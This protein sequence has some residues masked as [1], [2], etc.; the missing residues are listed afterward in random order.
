MIEQPSTSGKKSLNKL[1]AIISIVIIVATAVVIV[2]EEKKPTTTTSK[3]VEFHTW[4]A[5]EGK[6]ALDHLGPN[7]TAATGYTMTPYISPGVGGTNAI[8]AILSLMEAGKPPA[9]FQIHYG[10]AMLSHVEAASNGTKPF[11]NR[12]PVM[13]Q[14]SLTNNTFPSVLEAGEFN[15]LSL[16]MR[17]NLYQGAQLYFNPQILKKYDLPIPN[18]ISTLVSDTLALKQDGVTPWIIPG[19]DWGWDQLNLWEDIFLGLAGNT[20][21]DDLMYRTLNMS[22][23]SVMHIMNETCDIYSIFQNDS[24]PGE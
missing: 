3:T 23:P 6:V 7:F 24:Y 20:M 1:T 5:T 17:V 19:A 22:N 14:M 18:N 21:Y 4:W 10:P 2:V 16:S 8:Y 9:S 13:N 15:G 11:V 12:G